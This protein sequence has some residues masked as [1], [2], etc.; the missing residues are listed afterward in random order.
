MTLRGG[1]ER[2]PDLVLYVNGIAVAVIEPKSSRAGVGEDIRQLRSNQRPE[3]SAGF[4]TRCSGCLPATT[5]WA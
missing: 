1:H 5:M 4:S 2:R 3:F